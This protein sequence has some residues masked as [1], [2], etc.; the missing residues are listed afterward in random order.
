MHR[1]MGIPVRFLSTQG[2][3]AAS[4][5]SSGAGNVGTSGSTL[6]PHP[7]CSSP[8]M[9]SM[10]RNSRHFPTTNNQPGCSTP[11]TTRNPRAMDQAPSRRSNSS[12]RFLLTP[13]NSTPPTTRNPR[14][15]NL[16]PSRR[17]NSSVRFLLTP[18]NSTPPTTRNPRAMDQAP[19]RGSNSSAKRRCTSPISEQQG[20]RRRHSRSEAMNIPVASVGQSSPDDDLQIVR[21]VPAQPQRPLSEFVPTGAQSYDCN[22]WTMLQLAEWAC[23]KFGPVHPIVKKILEN[24]VDGKKL[25]KAFE[26]YDIWHNARI[27]GFEDGELQK[28]YRELKPNFAALLLG[29]NPPIIN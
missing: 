5:P 13:G 24:E 10:P 4:P 1:G 25:N 26:I 8:P 15:M 28:M 6:A 27:F 17:S 21:V 19:S 16:A 3:T 29:E 9:P 23:K 7:P 12:V 20:Q 2:S 14:A 11:P 18:G 22:R